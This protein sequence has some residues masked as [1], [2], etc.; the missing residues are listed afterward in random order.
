MLVKSVIFFAKMVALASRYYST[1][2]KCNTFE[3]WF[4]CTTIVKVGI[5][6]P[7]YF[8]RD[9]NLLYLVFVINSFT[10]MWLS[11][12]LRIRTQVALN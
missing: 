7:L 5:I 6:L 2:G 4:C 12:V 10:T 1:V 3:I 8:I 9:I 11:H